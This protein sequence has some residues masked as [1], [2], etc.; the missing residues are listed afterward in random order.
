LQLLLANLHDWVA[1]SYFAPSWRNLSLEK[2]TQMIYRKEGRV[3]W[4]SDHIE[5]M[6]EP[7]RYSDQQRAMEITCARFNEA[8]VHWRDG[9]LLR[10]SVASP[11]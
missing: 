6:L 11:G 7:Y 5:V 9:R 8:S 4:H 1:K 3:T 10:I 2:A